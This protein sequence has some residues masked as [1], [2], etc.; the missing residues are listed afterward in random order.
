MCAFRD[1]FWLQA[2]EHNGHE[3]GFSPVWV[4]I[5]LLILEN[6]SIILVQKGHAYCL[7]PIFMGPFWKKIKTRDFYLHSI[8]KQD[9]FIN[10]NVISILLLNFIKC[11]YKAVH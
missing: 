5:C 7:I 9:F 11:L 10:C 1:V 3:N 8:P 6:W 2:K 4:K